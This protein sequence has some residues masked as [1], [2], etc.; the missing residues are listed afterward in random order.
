MNTLK[1]LKVITLFVL[2]II[3]IVAATSVRRFIDLSPIA[4]AK[5]LT[6]VNGSI[7]YHIQ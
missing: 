6:H 4:Q 7:A 3:L 1:G 5:G 2:A